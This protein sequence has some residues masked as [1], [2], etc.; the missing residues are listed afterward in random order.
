MGPRLAS[1]RLSN[2][3]HTEHAATQPKSKQ[4]PDD[5]R[6]TGM[7][8]TLASGTLPP[9]TSIQHPNPIHGDELCGRVLPQQTGEGKVPRNQ[10]PHAP[11]PAEPLFPLN[12]NRRENTEPPCSCLRTERLHG[13]TL[14]PST[15]APF[16][17]QEGGRAQ[18]LHSTRCYVKRAPGT[19]R[20]GWSAHDQ[21]KPACNTRNEAA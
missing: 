3:P 16:L 20:F 10:R 18:L 7:G 2:K 1:P 21:V 11:L 12:N 5:D 17:K 6:N 9:K 8:G 14:Q 15:R 4:N 13:V 19:R